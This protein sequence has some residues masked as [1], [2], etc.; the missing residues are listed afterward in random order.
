MSSIVVNGQSVAEAIADTPGVTARV[1][2]GSTTPKRPRINFIEGPDITIGVVDDGV[3]DEIE[4]TISATGTAF[5]GFYAGAMGQDAGAGSPGVSGQAARGDHTHPISTAY[6]AS[7]YRVRSNGGS[8]SGSGN[9]SLA[10]NDGGS[11][12]PRLAINIGQIAAGANTLV[13]AAVSTSV[14]ACYQDAGASSV[15]WL[16]NFIRGGGDQWQ[17]DTFDSSNVRAARVAGPN[18]YS[19]V[20]FIIGDA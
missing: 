8:V 13:G 18:T 9:L 19:G 15:V 1:N 2:S 7:S 6:R 20:F 10:P 5:P 4:V 3:D 11:Y 12:T 16:S 17:I 14:E